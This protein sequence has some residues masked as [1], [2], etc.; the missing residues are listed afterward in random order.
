MT[1]ELGPVISWRRQEEALRPGISKEN[2]GP[3]LFARMA[4]RQERDKYPI[5]I[6]KGT[7]TEQG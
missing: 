1:R 3:G 5:L 7:G 4:Q 2:P 6:Q